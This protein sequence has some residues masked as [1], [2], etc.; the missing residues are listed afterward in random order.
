MLGCPIDAADDSI[1]FATNHGVI[2][3]FRKCR[4]RLFAWTMTIIIK[5][6]KASASMEL[7]K[8]TVYLRQKSDD[9]L[10]RLLVCIILILSLHA[11]YNV[12]N[13]RTVVMPWAELQTNS[14]NSRCQHFIKASAC[15]GGRVCVISVHFGTFLKQA[16]VA[17]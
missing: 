9:I 13:V 1:I 6:E 14:A 11:S 15:I 5:E 17:V 16:C 3:E 10:V 7:H 2:R 12:F 8:V 4:F